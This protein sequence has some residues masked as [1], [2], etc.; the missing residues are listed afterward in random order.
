MASDAIFEYIDT[1]FS[2][3]RCATKTY[4]VPFSTYSGFADLIEW[5]L[6]YFGSVLT[7]KFK[8]A[9]DAILKTIKS[10]IFCTKCAKKA[11]EA[12]F[13]TKFGIPDLMERMFLCSET[14]L[15]FKSKM[16]AQ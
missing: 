9:A 5:Y 13:P 15:T 2:R 1:D 14:I 6:L 10:D 7:F 16:A 12:T 8:M 4:E 11:N 3:A